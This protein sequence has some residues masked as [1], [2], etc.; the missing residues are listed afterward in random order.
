[1]S[2]AIQWMQGLLVDEWTLADGSR[3]RPTCFGRIQIERL[4]VGLKERRNNLDQAVY[5]A[6][7]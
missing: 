3:N 5:G 2:K 4:D 1:M 6:W 7:N